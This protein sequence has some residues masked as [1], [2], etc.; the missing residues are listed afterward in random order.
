M[1]SNNII[2]LKPT[3]DV[4]RVLDFVML[5]RSLFSRNY[6]PIYLFCINRNCFSMIPTLFI[7]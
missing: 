7:A 5:E 1:Q 2:W 4:K 3:N 6:K